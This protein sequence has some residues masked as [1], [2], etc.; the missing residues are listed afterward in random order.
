MG[1]DYGRI[2][3]ASTSDLA[4]MPT[5]RAI[6]DAPPTKCMLPN[7]SADDAELHIRLPALQNELNIPQEGA[8][9][10][11]GSIIANVRSKST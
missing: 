5:R 4:S 6:K 11:Q 1:G 9:L 3:F 8:F 10:A 7:R 2:L